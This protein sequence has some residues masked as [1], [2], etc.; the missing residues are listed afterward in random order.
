[1]PET[2]AQIARKLAAII[3]QGPRGLALARKLA[4]EG[5]RSR[6]DLKRTSVLERLP[7]EARANVL[8]NPYRGA[9]FAVASA[10]A[11]EFKRRAVFEFANGVVRFEVIPVGSVRRKA[12]RSKDLDFLIVV[13]PKYRSRALAALTLRPRKRGDKIE[14]ATVYAAGARRRSV[15]LRVEGTRAEGTRVEGTR[16]EGTRVEGTRAR[17]YRA[18]VFL[19]TAAEKPF[20][21]LHYTGPYDY[22]IRVRAH[23]KRNGR[24]LNQYGLFSATTRARARVRGSNAVSN[25]RDLARLLGITYRAPHLRD[26]ARAN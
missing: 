1:M 17:N 9:T 18:D 19:A 12:P 14:I 8:Y 15:I 3:G 2:V 20:A 13:P 21:L 16:A 7:V 25:E 5:V 11:N 6:A 10:I 23:A 26:G 24:L 4:R 22:N